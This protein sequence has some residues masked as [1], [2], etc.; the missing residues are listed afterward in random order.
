[1]F[2]KTN[3]SFVV[4][5]LLFLT[6]RTLDDWDVPKDEAVEND[7]AIPEKRTKVCFASLISFYYC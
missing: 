5:P 1:M 4:M 3:L 7:A 6:D 2:P